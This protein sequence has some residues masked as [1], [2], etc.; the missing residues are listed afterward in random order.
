MCG[1]Q[2]FGFRVYVLKFTRQGSGLRVED[3]RIQVLG[4]GVWDLGTLSTVPTLSN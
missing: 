1:V 3:F 2:G 4:F